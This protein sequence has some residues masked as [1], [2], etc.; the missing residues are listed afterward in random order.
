MQRLIRAAEIARA[1][2][3]NGTSPIS[4]ARPV[5]PRKSRP[6]S[7][8]STSGRGGEGPRRLAP[9]P[10]AGRLADP[11]LHPL[12]PELV[13]VAVEEHVHRLLHRLRREELG[14]RTPE[15]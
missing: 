13:A 6:P 4:R 14:I 9:R 1:N 10:R 2:V 11:R 12:A 3:L 8:K 7:A 15:H 5:S